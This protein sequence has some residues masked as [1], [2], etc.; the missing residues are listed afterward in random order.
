[1]FSLEELVIR[2]IDKRGYSVS[3]ELFKSGVKHY[4]NSLRALKSLSIFTPVTY[5]TC[6]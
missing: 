1:M 6:D 3:F 4:Q 5:V 2:N